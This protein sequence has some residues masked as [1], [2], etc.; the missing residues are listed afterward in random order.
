MSALPGL[1]NLPA[2]HNGAQGLRPLEGRLHLW[3]AGL[4]AT[5]DRRECCGVPQRE[6]QKVRQ[7]TNSSAVGSSSPPSGADNA[8]HRCLGRDSWERPNPTASSGPGGRHALSILS[9]T[10]HN[11][12]S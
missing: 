10:G 4:H 6:P 12:V 9:E 11:L 3:E 2:K 5:E 8:D 7:I 1:Q